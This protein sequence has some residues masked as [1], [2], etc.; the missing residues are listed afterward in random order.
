MIKGVSTSH[1]QVPHHLPFLPDQP[2]PVHITPRRPSPQPPWRVGQMRTWD[3][4]SP[5][6]RKV[7]VS[8]HP[9]HPQ[10][11]CVSTTASPARLYLC[12]VPDSSSR[13]PEVW[14]Q[15]VKSNNSA[16]VCTPLL[17]HQRWVVSDS[18]SGRV[19]WALLPVDPTLKVWRPILGPL[20]KGTSPTLILRRVPG[21]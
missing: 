9:P 2:L 10:H 17:P 1:E 15:V 18:H 21:E 16:Q 7:C 19:G 6:R 8:L 11:V 4:P 20:A 14:A 12:H 5:P 13:N 3:G